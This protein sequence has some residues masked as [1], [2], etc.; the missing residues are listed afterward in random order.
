MI[1]RS[2]AICCLVGI[3]TLLVMGDRTLLA[4]GRRGGDDSRRRGGDER[5]NNDDR[6]SDEGRREDFRERMRERFAAGGFSGGEFGGGGFGGFGNF[7]PGGGNPFGEGG[8]RDRDNNDD[9]SDAP[10]EKPRVTVDLPGDYLAGDLD[11]DGQIGFYEW[12][13]WQKTGAA[14]FARWDTNNDGFLTPRELVGVAAPSGSARSSSTVAATS[15][16]ASP[17][18]NPFASSGSSRTQ[19]SSGRPV[20]TGP[21]QVDSNDPV[22]LKAKNYFSLMDENKDGTVTPDELEKSNRVKSMFKD[23]G[24]DLTKPMNSDQFVET[25]VRVSSS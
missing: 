2:R 13:L 4:Q 22:A 11:Q 24:I 14:Q 23:A 15:S 25:Y 17:P 9:D 19:S 18:S 8:G 6:D 1:P 10:I 5:G 3:A 12:R 21:V 7:V 20:A 16:R